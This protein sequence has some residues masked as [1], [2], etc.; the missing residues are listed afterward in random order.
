M[1]ILIPHTWLLEHLETDISPEKLQSAVSLCGPSIE[2]IYDREGDNVYDIEVTT[3][4]VDAMSVRGIAREAA[5]ILQQFGIDAKLKPSALPKSVA[6]KQ[7]DE[8][9]PLPKIINDPNLS[10]RVICI[11]LKGV[12][13]NQTPEWMAKRLLQTEQNVHD[14]VIDIT[15]YIT[16]EL[17]HPCHAFDYDKLMQ[18]GGEINVVEAKKGETFVT[19]DGNEF[20]TVGG[21]VVF[22]NGE[23]DII[24][25]PSIKGTANTSI[26]DSTQN[27]LLLLE[28]IKAEKV[29]FASMTHA[30]RTV[31]AQLMEKNVDPNLAKDVLIRGVQ[32]YQE[33]CDAQIASEIYDDF[34]GDKPLKPVHVKLQTIHEYLGST[35]S[36]ENVISTQE[37]ISILEQLECKVTLEEKIATDSGQALLVQP[38]TFRPDL[39]IPADIVEE[40][41]RIYGYHNLPSEIMDTKI[42]TQRQEGVNFT[43]ENRIKRFLAS[44]GLQEIYSYSMVSEAIAQQTDALES[45]LKLQ[46]PLTDDRVY[47]RKSLIPSLNEILDQNSHVSDLS[48]FEIA[49]V[50]LPKIN[51]LPFEKL[52]LSIV[53]TQPYRKVR[54]ILDSLLAQLF[55]K[56]STV[57]QNSDTK[58]TIS[59]LDNG[60]KIDLGTV[61]IL[62][63]KRI[64][65]ELEFAKILQVAK[66]H[67]TYQPIPTTA[68]ITE[69]MTFTLPKKIRVGE[70]IN[71]ILEISDLVTNVELKDIYKQNYSFTITYH[72]P[73]NNLASDDLRSIR[74]K[75][76]HALEKEQGILV[77]TV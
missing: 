52:R 69:D 17:G 61:Q 36:G 13:R 49:N 32:L 29:R 5:V 55:I 47:L 62:E 21:E 64:A 72:D 58:G 63:K 19:L 25:L 20:E 7:G 73:K 53:S 67:P 76:V 38:P 57:T 74:K 12:K 75:I 50:Y 65:I 3:N 35:E 59:V 27:V 22:K 30:I 48:V 11:V 40:I 16:H 8:L 23:G 43:I 24:D 18:T 54:G 71:V 77:G 33:L 42:P 60:K 39:T 6:P 70:I 66:T 4:R 34:P 2:R 10:K 26:D 45:H 44:I 46:N 15:N 41:A 56:N 14:A 9:L 51:D 68:I 37:I 1:N 31:A 28:S